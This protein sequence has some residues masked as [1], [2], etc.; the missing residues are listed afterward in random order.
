M[1]IVEP[2][3]DKNKISRIK[4]LLQKTS[5]RNLLLFV[6]GINSGLRISDLLELKIKDVFT[7]Q[8][9][10]RDAVV[11]QEQKTAKNKKFAINKSINKI[12]R[13][14]VKEYNIDPATD[15]E[16]YLFASRKGKN[17][18]ISKVQAYRI[19]NEA[20]RAAGVTEN[21]G[22]HTLRKS[23]GYHA[24]S[25]G[26]DLSLLQQI[27]NHHSQKETLRYIGITQDQIDEV[28]VKIEL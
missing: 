27:F 15:R 10:V 14:F 11:I 9:K 5:T 19:I 18:P 1:N 6:F 13:D 4:K 2:I 3:R 8:G 25:A 20:A 16:R 7:E 17:K 24:Y 26:T 12:L 21:I 23:F 22:T 28:Y